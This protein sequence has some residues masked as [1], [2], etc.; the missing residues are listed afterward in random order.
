MNDANDKLLNDKLLN[1]KLKIILLSEP[2]PIIKNILIKCYEENLKFFYNTLEYFSFFIKYLENRIDN[3]ILLK[4]SLIKND[5]ENMNI[6]NLYNIYQYIINS[7]NKYGL[8]YQNL[9]VDYENN[10]NNKDKENIELNVKYRINKWK[11]KTSTN[12]IKILGNLSENN[13]ILAFSQGISEDIRG[14]SGIT[15]ISSEKSYSE[16]KGIE[17]KGPMKKNIFFEN[18]QKLNILDKDITHITDFLQENKINENNAVKLIS[19]LFNGVL[20]F[21]FKNKKIFDKNMCINYLIKFYYYHIPMLNI[22]NKLD[23]FPNIDIMNYY[24][25]FFDKGFSFYEKIGISIENY[26]RIF[27]NFNKLYNLKITKESIINLK[28]NIIEQLEQLEQNN[29]EK[30]LNFIDKTVGDCRDLSISGAKKISDNLN[31][32]ENIKNLSVNIAKILFGID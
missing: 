6:F 1:D 13:K 17:R 20:Y 11:G 18:T 2:E 9:Y 19:N 16:S 21:N 12:N 23:N 3:D 25:K 29:K 22:N 14:Q 8:S 26:N 27:S 10:L 15:Y 24:K 28:K 32:D 31:K 4:I 5:I 30:L 7:F